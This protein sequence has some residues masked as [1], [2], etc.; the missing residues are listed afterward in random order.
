MSAGRPAIAAERRA[1]L[2][3][4]GPDP[5]AVGWRCVDLMEQVMPQIEA[6][7]YSTEDALVAA[8]AYVVGRYSTAPVGPLDAS[9]IPKLIDLYDRRLTARIAAIAERDGE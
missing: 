5:A 2:A 7:G 6:E 1:I 9:Y 3:A 8:A 4:G